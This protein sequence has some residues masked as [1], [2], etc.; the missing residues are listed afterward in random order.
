MNVRLLLSAVTLPL[1]LTQCGPESMLNPATE[2]DNQPV[3]PR[4]PETAF[5]NDPSGSRI[6]YDD[7]HGENTYRLKKT[8]IY[9]FAS[10][11]W[12]RKS[13]DTRTGVWLYKKTGPKTGDLIFDVDDVWHLKFTSRNR[14]SAKND[15][16]KRT[17]TFEFEWE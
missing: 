4:G 8:H 15:G 3:I 12:N 14:A 9:Q 13:T 5:V 11:S 6:V 16:D 17:Y 10:L 2:V 1:V 7:N